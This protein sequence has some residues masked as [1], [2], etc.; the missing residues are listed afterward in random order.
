M[1]RSPGATASSPLPLFDAASPCLALLWLFRTIHQ[2]APQT[3]FASC[4]MPEGGSGGDGG[5]GGG[6]PPDAL[7]A[8][9]HWQ[10]EGIPNLDQFFTRVYR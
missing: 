9:E 7:L 4:S 2:S 1:S 3:H 8:S 10:W 6:A 5:E